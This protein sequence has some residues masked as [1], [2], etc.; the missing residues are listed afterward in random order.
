MVRS[1]LYKLARSPLFYLGV[2]GTAA[3]CLVL[4]ISSG[5]NA[6]GGKF[7]WLGADV[8]TEFDLLLGVSSLR[9][10]TVVLGALPFAAN[11]AEEWQSGVTIAAVARKGVKSYS[12]ANVLCVFLSSFIAVFLGLVLFAGILSVFLP[13]YMPSNNPV[14]FLYGVILKSA[15]PFLYIMLK[16]LV[17]A[18]SCAAWSVMGLMLSA[19]LPNKYVSIC[20]PF[21]AS[22]IVERI[23]MQLPDPI[24]L[25]V[26][27]LSVL[28]WKNAL[29]SF[30]YSVL[31]FLLIACI[32]GMVFGI[33]VKR[34]VENGFS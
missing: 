17:F 28:P 1:Y 25:Y 3:L 34:R 20:A 24:N 23:T 8:Y 15:F 22:Y 30:F 5:Y 2:F 13:V 4:R 11:F 19:F 10:M 32:C 9:K 21:V 26:I 29:L 14:S 18:L 27:S 12:L 16:S 31:L 7:M 6:G 33:V